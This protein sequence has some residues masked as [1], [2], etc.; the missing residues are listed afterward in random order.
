[1]EIIWTNSAVI[2]NLDNIEYLLDEWNI[3]VVLAYEEKVLEI[4]KLI[5]TNP[6]IG[7]YDKDL[8]LYKRLVVPQIYMMYEIRNEKIFILRMWNN[9]K[10]PYW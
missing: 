3:N 5:L 1:M 2:D 10:K 8:N 6:E 4:E 7:I 9:Y